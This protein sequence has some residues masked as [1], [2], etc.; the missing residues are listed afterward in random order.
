M[1]KNVYLSY[2]PGNSA[3]G[4][5][6]ICCWMTSTWSVSS[7]VIE[8]RKGR[9]S[10]PAPW[11]Y[12]AFHRLFSQAIPTFAAEVR[13]GWKP[14][15]KHQRAIFQQRHV[16]SSLSIF[17]CVI[18]VINLPTERT[19]LNIHFMYILGGVYIW[20]VHTSLRTHTNRSSQYLEHYM[21]GSCMRLAKK[22]IKFKRRLDNLYGLGDWES[23][24][25]IIIIII[26]II[27]IRLYV[28]FISKLVQRHLEGFCIRISSLGV[29]HWLAF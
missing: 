11:R 3:N 26:I 12:A 29:V 9:F 6:I 20:I 4:K 10:P 5:R 25:I 18:N 2:T 14:Q 27:A 28:K 22:R 16:G 15:W 21:F 8:V 19:F 7:I 24:I 23:D 1:F 13:P 17:W